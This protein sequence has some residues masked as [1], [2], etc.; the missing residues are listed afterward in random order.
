MN[1]T[2]RFLL[3]LVILLTLPINI[4]SA[5]EVST[6]EVR[7]KEARTQE[8]SQPDI[9]SE[10]SEEQKVKIE[11][12]K[13]NLINYLAQE[14]RNNDPIKHQLYIKYYVALHEQN[15]VKQ[16]T[17]TKLKRF[18][19]QSFTGRRYA[20]LEQQL[21]QFAQTNKEQIIKKI[22]TT[23]EEATNFT[24]NKTNQQENSTRRSIVTP[25]PPKKKIIQPS[26]TKQ[27]QNELDLFDSIRE[28][29]NDDMVRVGTELYED[30][31]Q[32]K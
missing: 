13:E 1:I 20:W 21:I 7:S 18:D 9:T 4:Y 23:P 30:N 24:P 29:S 32:S 5:Q 3:T 31:M 8:V 16:K 10:L 26:I 17:I 22:P 6:E 19:I 12:A 15:Q 28:N 2:K 14:K 27:T 11:L 25:T